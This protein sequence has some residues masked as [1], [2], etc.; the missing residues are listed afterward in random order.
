MTTQAPRANARTPGTQDPP[1]L[2]VQ[3]EAV[4]N[5]LAQLTTDTT[6]LVTTNLDNCDVMVAGFGFQAGGDTV[7]VTR[8]NGEKESFISGPQIVMQ[9]KVEDI[10][11][12]DYTKQYFPVKQKADGTLADP[13]SSSQYGQWLSVM[14]GFGVSGTQ[15][16][17]NRYLMRSLNDLL[18]LRYH[19]QL[20]EFPG[21]RGR[22]LQVS[23]PT[24]LF[25]FNNEFRASL[26][27][28]EAQLADA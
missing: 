3:D 28:P 27:L 13:Q 10:D 19:R 24:E 15:E 1:I 2:G 20:Q 5:L 12:I 8:D 9:L 6:E 17:A 11:G 22:A 14:A 26:G 16:I 21:F 25:G 18:G 4:Q 23:V 7:E